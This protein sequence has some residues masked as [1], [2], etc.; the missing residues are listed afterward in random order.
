MF[1]GRLYGVVLP[2]SKL[3]ALLTTHSQ[4]FREIVDGLVA[5][6]CWSAENALDLAVR[7]GD[8]K[9]HD[10][11][12]FYNH[13]QPEEY[14]LGRMGPPMIV[15]G[16]GFTETDEDSLVLDPLLLESVDH[17]LGVV[18]EHDAPRARCLLFCI[19]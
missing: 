7:R 11:R 3:V 12:V 15:V 4:A 14:A 2:A 9:V 6:G 1:L 19:A 8:C 10:L 13:A 5:R 18:F 17:A 16:N